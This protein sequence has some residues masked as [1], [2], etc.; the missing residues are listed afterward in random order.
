MSDQFDDLIGRYPP[1]TFRGPTDPRNNSALHNQSQFSGQS[2]TGNNL[3]EVSPKYPAGYRSAD[4]NQYLQ[5]YRPSV[6]AALASTAPETG[7][8]GMQE[9][10]VSSESRSE[11][12]DEEKQAT[13]TEGLQTVE[14][15]HSDRE[16]NI[17]QG[18]GREND[19]DEDRT[20]LLDAFRDDDD[21]EDKDKD[22]E[23]E[24]EDSVEDKELGHVGPVKPRV[25][26]SIPETVGLGI[27]GVS[28]INSDVEPLSSREIESLKE[29]QQGEEQEIGFQALKTTDIGVNG[30]IRDQ[31]N[32]GIDPVEES[33]LTEEDDIPQET[34]D[35]GDKIVSPTEEDDDILIP[36][37]RMR[38]E[39]NDE[40]NVNIQKDERRDL[41]TNLDPSLEDTNATSS[42]VLNS[43]LP[44]VTTPLNPLSQDDDTILTST[45]PNLEDLEPSHVIPDIQ[46]TTPVA[47]LGLKEDSESNQLAQDNIST[48]PRRRFRLSHYT[49]SDSTS[50]MGQIDHYATQAEDHVLQLLS[51][52]V[53]P[54]TP[55]SKIRRARRG[56]PGNPAYLSMMYKQTEGFQPLLSRLDPT[57]SKKLQ[58]TYEDVKKLSKLH[59]DS[60]TTERKYKDRFGPHWETKGW[61]KVDEDVNQKMREAY[62]DP[63]GSSVGTY[64]MDVISSLKADSIDGQQFQNRLEGF[65]DMIHGNRKHHTDLRDWISRNT[66]PE[67]STE[68]GIKNNVSTSK[69]EKTE[70]RKKGRVSSMI[71]PSYTQARKR[72]MQST[73]RTGTKYNPTDRKDS[74]FLPDE[75]GGVGPNL[76]AWNKTHGTTASVLITL[77]EM[78]LL[79]DD[80]I[81][82]LTD[83][84]VIKASTLIDNTLENPPAGEYAEGWANRY[85]NIRDEL[86]DKDHT[87]TE[88]ER[89][90]ARVELSNMIRDAVNFNGQKYGTDFEIMSETV[91]TEAVSRSVRRGGGTNVWLTSLGSVKNLQSAIKKLDMRGQLLVEL[92]MLQA[93]TGLTKY[94]EPTNPDNKSSPIRT[95]FKN[96]KTTSTVNESEAEGSTRTVRIPMSAQQFQ[97]IQSLQLIQ[98]AISKEISNAEN[99]VTT[100]NSVTRQLR[101]NIT[102]LERLVDDPSHTVTEAENDELAALRQYARGALQDLTTFRTTTAVPSFASVPEYSSFLNDNH[103]SEMERRKLSNVASMLIS[104]VDHVIKG[105]GEGIR[106]HKALSGR[107]LTKKSKIKSQ[108]SN[109]LENPSALSEI[110]GGKK[111][112]AISTAIDSGTT[113]SRLESISMLDSLPG[114]SSTITA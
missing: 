37:E 64:E 60:K 93:K 81:K 80:F 105:M 55:I 66:T 46:I 102:T 41:L 92:S 62:F 88:Q 99:T 103:M 42:I 18:S 113:E 33:I 77:D 65:V 43:L 57:L 10:Q 78:D 58:S 45:L 94:K 4:N 8:G 85:L 15:E 59:Y 23:E 34:F 68:D 28:G 19:R 89:T 30:F 104:T 40:V 13:H 20:R 114:S 53:I 95:S 86:V 110:N 39:G 48:S 51:G 27:Q 97:I 72:I 21:E 73:R 44:V 49:Y 26:M 11:H 100:F 9:D 108:G 111:S 83:E 70:E 75:Y 2:A 24:D 1:G 61:D 35:D 31:D 14:E 63:L 5:D 87:L 79:P 69:V 29:F 25:T 50:F 7:Y 3:P 16:E 96:D 112:E 82:T 36:S 91:A 106:K 107:E 38:V 6:N 90:D 84:T 56:P 74:L 17:G 67:E 101:T 109:G 32:N 76:T 22:T 47:E 52:T 12:D 54:S 98:Q 71:V